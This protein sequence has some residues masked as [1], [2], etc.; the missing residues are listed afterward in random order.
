MLSFKTLVSVA[1]LGLG[2]AFGP[3]SAEPL[4]VAFAAEP[5]P[6]FTEADASGKWHGFEVD[7]ADALCA[8]MKAECVH[9]P[10]AW[11]GIIPALTSG[12]V[13]M[14]VAPCRSPKSASRPSPSLTVIITPR[15]LS[16]APR[17]RDRYHA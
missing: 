7:I 3:A 2:L 17:D 15:R 16:S 8:Q 5:Y 11:D 12:Q 9:T 13:D 6:P 10:V 4:K 1:A 14:I